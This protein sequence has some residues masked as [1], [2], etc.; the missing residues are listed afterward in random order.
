MEEAI[1]AGVE[2]LF[3][4]CKVTKDSLEIVAVRNACREKVRRDLSLWEMSPESIALELCHSK[5]ILPSYNSTDP[6]VSLTDTKD[7]DTYKLY[8]EQVHEIQIR[9]RKP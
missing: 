4:E 1:E 3:I 7:F 8:L 6:R 9:G 5:T 2:I